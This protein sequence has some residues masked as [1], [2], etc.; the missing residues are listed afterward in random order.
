MLLIAL[1]LNLISFPD[2]SLLVLSKEVTGFK[3]AKSVTVDGRG[4][5]FVL[6]R[7][8]SE[9]SKFDKDLNLLTKSGGIGWGQNQFVSPEYIDASSGLD[10]LVSDYQNNRIQRL[11]LKLSFVSE[12]NTEELTFPD[13]YKV[14]FPKATLVVNSKDIYVIDGNNPRVVIFK[15]GQTPVS[16]FG[17]FGSGDAELIEPHKILKNGDNLLF[18]L[19]KGRNSIMKFDNFGNFRGKIEKDNIISISMYDNILY[20]LLDEEVWLFNTISN[21]FDSVIS[22]PHEINVKKITDFL[23]ITEICIY[24]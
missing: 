12:L 5:I 23:V 2:S 17:G 14:R 6:D 15:N 11:D 9:I 10:I 8:T 13:E 18:I 19:D 4:S 24:F 21:Q 22:I 1:V 16:V 20:I 3:Y 7:E